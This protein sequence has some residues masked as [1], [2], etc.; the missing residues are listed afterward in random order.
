MNI[1][2]DL[3]WA[4]WDGVLGYYKEKKDYLQTQL[5]NPEGPDKPNKKFYDPR[6]WLRAGELGFVARLRQ[7]F[8]DLNNVNTLA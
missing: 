1:D 4:T 5:G 2:T 6:A 8:E 7:A 3:Q